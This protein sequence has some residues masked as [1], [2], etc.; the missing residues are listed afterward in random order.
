MKAVVAVVAVA[1]ELSLKYAAAVVEN[2]QVA[3][4]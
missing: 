1:T 2:I 4:E 3:V